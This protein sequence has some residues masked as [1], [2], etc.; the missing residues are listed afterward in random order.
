MVHSMALCRAGC[1]RKGSASGCRSPYLPEGLQTPL[2]LFRRCSVTQN[3][4]IAVVRTYFEIDVI[5]A[6]PL[7]KQFLDEVDISIEL[8]ADWPLGGL[9]A[10]VAFDAEVHFLATGSCRLLA[11]FGCCGAHCPEGLSVRGER[12]F[13]RSTR[14]E[15]KTRG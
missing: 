2:S 7:I 3:V 9:E 14:Q 5:R 10:G 4:Q 11:G 8:K 15:R 6:V 12:F 1:K 13:S